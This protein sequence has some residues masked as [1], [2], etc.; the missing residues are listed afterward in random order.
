MPVVVTSSS[1]TKITHMADQKARVTFAYKQQK[2][3]ELHKINAMGFL[4]IKINREKLSKF[5]LLL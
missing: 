1:N 3:P 5:S 2:I 4:S